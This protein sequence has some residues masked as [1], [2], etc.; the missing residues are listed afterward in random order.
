[1]GWLNH[2]DW[3]QRNIK[4]PGDTIHLLHMPI[5][6]IFMCIS[7]IFKK[8]DLGHLTEGENTGGA[9][10]PPLFQKGGWVGL[11]PLTNFVIVFC[12]FLH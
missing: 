11:S 9:T 12:R 5:I 2:L 8:E 3:R 1:M 10:A 4:L 6:L 7:L